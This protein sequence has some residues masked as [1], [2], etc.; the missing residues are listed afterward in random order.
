M[1]EPLAFGFVLISAVCVCM[2]IGTGSRLLSLAQDSETFMNCS[3]SRNL[4]VGIPFV[5][6][7]PPYH[8]RSIESRS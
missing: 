1:D 8:M 7:H 5:S 3:I 4:T 6:Y 2:R